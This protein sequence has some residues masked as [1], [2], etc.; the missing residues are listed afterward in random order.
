MTKTLD[1]TYRDIAYN[2]DKNIFILVGDNGRDGK[3][4]FSTNGKNWSP[5]YTCSNK[6]LYKAVWDG[7]RY[8]AVGDSGTIIISEDG[9]NWSS[10][11]TE[12]TQNLYDIVYDDDTFIAVGAGDTHISFK[13][14]EVYSMI[15][16]LT[17]S[18]NGRNV[19]L[20]WTAVPEAE[21]YRVYHTDASG[22]YGKGSLVNS[23]I[24][25]KNSYIAQ[26]EDGNNYYIVRP[27]FK[28]G[29]EGED[30]NEAAVTFSNVK[31][32][33][34]QVNNRYMVVDGVKREIDAQND[35]V[36]IIQNGRVLVPIKSIIKAMNGQTLWDKKTKRITVTVDK[37]II[38]MWLNSTNIRV[39]GIYSDMDV[40]PTIVKGRTL[41]PLRFV[42]RNLLCKVNWDQK[43]KKVTI[44]PPSF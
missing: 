41:L 19:N 30:S 5:V 34:L 22:E 39:N 14:T 7:K 43:T 13:T 32:I 20:T 28:D 42:A 16:D 17:A 11:K 25:R 27:V 9:T 21:G 37:I 38:E 10:L 26:A 18:L 36:P 29:H 31:S 33:V 6:K 23:T 40:A 1:E 4:Y 24:I 2:D 35:V 8:V 12:A 44:S 3:V 15:N